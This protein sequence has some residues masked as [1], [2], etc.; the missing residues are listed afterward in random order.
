MHLIISYS[1]DRIITYK[2]VNVSKSY[3]LFFLGIT[4]PIYKLDQLYIQDLN[5]LCFMNN[6]YT[7]YYFLWNLTS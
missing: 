1:V 6:L 2:L 5:N 3:S 4:P 7:D